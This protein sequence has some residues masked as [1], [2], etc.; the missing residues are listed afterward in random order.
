[1]KNKIKIERRLNVLIKAL[2]DIEAA[3]DKTNDTHRCIQNIAYNA[4][5]NNAAMINE[6]NDSNEIV[7]L[8]DTG[9]FH[10]QLKGKGIHTAINKGGGRV[11]VGLSCDEDAEDTPPHEI[12]NNA[13]EFI[14]EYYK[15]INLKV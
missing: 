12:M 2:C 11:V 3:C 4:I 10:K 9:S 5:K 13:K 7:N 8:S 6:D 1:M 14:S 15:N